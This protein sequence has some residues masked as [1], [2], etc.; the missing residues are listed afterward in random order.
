M[1]TTPKP[2][3]ARLIPTTPFPFPRVWLSIS[4]MIADEL[5]S[6]ADEVAWITVEPGTEMSW[7]RLNAWVAVVRS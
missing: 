5:V 7:K 3:A 6:V 4:P 2:L 1:P